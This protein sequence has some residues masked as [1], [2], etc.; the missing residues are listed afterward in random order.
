MVRSS[1]LS[2][3]ELVLIVVDTEYG[4]AAAVA[5]AVGDDFDVDSFENKVEVIVAFA[6]KNEF[7]K[8]VLLLPLFLMKTM[9]ME[10]NVELL[11]LVEVVD[12]RRQHHQHR[13][14]HLYLIP[15]DFD[16]V[17]V[18]AVLLFVQPLD[19]WFGYEM[20]AAVFCQMLPVYNRHCHHHH[21]HLQTA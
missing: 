4:A 18:V 6:E 8:N 19:D 15:I 13:S 3:I 7:Q 16:V 17:V 5:A 20:G 2:S 1:L 14:V 11:V 12:G 10:S 9:M 21:Q